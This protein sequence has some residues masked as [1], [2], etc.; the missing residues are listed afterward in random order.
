MMEWG[1]VDGVWRRKFVRLP[2]AEAM[3]DKK[4]NDWRW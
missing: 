3:A 4:S 2:V 1:S